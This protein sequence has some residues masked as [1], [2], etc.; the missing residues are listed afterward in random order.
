MPKHVATIASILTTSFATALIA[1]TVMRLG[2]VFLP[3]TSPLE[4]WLLYGGALL[5]LWC[6][7]SFLL[8]TACLVTSCLA[9]PPKAT[10]TVAIAAGLFV[11]SFFSILFVCSLPNQYPQAWPIAMIVALPFAWIGTIAIRPVDRP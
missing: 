9:D 3:Q 4:S 5:L 6:P 11:G 2:E 8:G 1:I 7:L 10:T